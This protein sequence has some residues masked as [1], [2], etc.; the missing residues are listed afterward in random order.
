MKVQQRK[1]SGA[2]AVE[3]SL[4]LSVWFLFIFGI[5]EYGRYIYTMQVMENAARE[6]S[7]MGLAHT[8]DKT[9]ADI[10]AFVEQKL[11]GVQGNLLGGNATITINGV[12]LRPKDATESVGQV[13]TDWSE[14]STTDGISVEI[15]GDFVPFLPSVTKLPPS[16]PVRTLS[17]MYSEGN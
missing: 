14:A 3:T 16:F 6:G 15:R 5:I 4:V 7:R 11:F 10:R 2:T 13:L 8:H 17:I 9:E 12:I 1:R